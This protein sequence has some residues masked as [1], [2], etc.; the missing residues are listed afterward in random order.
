VERPTA[1]INPCF[2]PFVMLSLKT[3]KL[4]GPGIMINIA[5]ATA[6]DKINSGSTY[7]YFLWRKE[8]TDGF[9]D[10]FFLKKSVIILT[11]FHP[12]NC[13]NLCHRTQGI[14]D[15]LQMFNVINFK[16]DDE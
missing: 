11:L 12:F 16:F 8:E 5:E 2:R 14:N 13:G 9:Y 1:M 7:I 3:N 10:N 4:S 6:K 15:I